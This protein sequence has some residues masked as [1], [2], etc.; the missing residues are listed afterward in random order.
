MAAR[1]LC[2]LLCVLLAGCAAHR[3][4]SQFPSQS[5]LAQIAPPPQT[6]WLVLAERR[7]VQDW[8]LE[9]P[10]PGDDAQRPVGRTSPWDQELEFA[11]LTS[12]PPLARTRAMACAAREFGRFFLQHGG[13]PAEGLQKYILSLC[14]SVAARARTAM[15][16]AQVPDEVPEAK[17]AG[18]W[19]PQVRQMIASVL[20]GGDHDRAGIWFGRKKGQA[21]VMVVM[22]GSRAQFSALP[23]IPDARGRIEIAGRLEED[24]Q[25]IDALVNHGRFG[26]EACKVD[27]NVPLPRFA[28]S[29]PVDRRDE[30]AWISISAFPP[31]HVLGDRVLDLI[32]WP[33]GV[34]TRRYVRPPRPA[35][36]TV[37]AAGA[38][39]QAL[40]RALNGV[41]REARIPDLELA[42][43]QS[44][45]AT[46]LA[47]AYLLALTGQE[48]R[49]TADKVALGMMAGWDVQGT[50]RHGRVTG[51]FAAQSQDVGD[52]LGAALEEPSGRYT[53]LDPEA[54]AIAIGPVA[55]TEGDSTL[56]GAL[57]GTY[58]FFDE[59]EDH[60][61][62][63]EAA[64]EKLVRAAREH[65]IR[66]VTR[67]DDLTSVAEEAAAAIHAGD[68]SP[69]HAMNSAL[70]VAAG[71][72]PGVQ[73]GGLYMELSELDQLTF[74]DDFFKSASMRVGIAVTHYKPSD[75][76]WG[77]YVVI[78]IATGERPMLTAGLGQGR[79]D[80]SRP[81]SGALLETGR[82]R[83]LARAGR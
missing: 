64:Y 29:C 17:L 72:K 71:L 34:R 10:L 62:A 41:R 67:A 42:R 5:E 32:V 16:F 52:L 2:A 81:R 74:E 78:V 37:A 68:W 46:R 83:R 36:E 65:G 43:K 1:G 38:L 75:W 11:A 66:D 13:Q 28:L 76:P 18:Q 80:P 7:D 25:S 56:L 45:T 30:Q 53:L 49:E 9:E 59:K 19:R 73:V 4:A 44:E 22:G 20:Q 8:T 14:G 40:L 57:I 39:P 6:R 54:R 82:L 77:R 21:V 58:S 23:R 15:L 35:S 26:V 60:A 50:V 63:E 33:A 27:P 70:G 69:E 55:H 61:A 79:S 31:G 24:A 51:A 47:P 12:M 3:V 48:P